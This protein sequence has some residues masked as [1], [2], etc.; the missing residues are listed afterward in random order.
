M[1]GKL[2]LKLLKTSTQN[3]VNY[4][5]DQSKFDKRGAAS[6]AAISV[7]NSNGTCTLASGSN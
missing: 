3:L 5:R 4:V 7:D 2:L 6:A 1:L